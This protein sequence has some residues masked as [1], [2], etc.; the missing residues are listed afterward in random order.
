VYLNDGFRDFLLP[1]ISLPDNS[2]NEGIA[3]ADFDN[4]GTLD[5]VIA[6]GGGQPD[7]VFGNDGAGNFTLLAELGSEPTPIDADVNFASKV[8]PAPTFSHDVAVADFNGDG[9]TDIVIAAIGGNP[10]YAGDGFGGFSPYGTLLGT[11]DSHAVAVA[12]FN[13]TTGPDIVFANV[14]G[15]SQVWLNNGINGFVAG[16]SLPIGDAVAVTVGQFGGDASPDLAFGRVPTINGDVPANPVLINDGSGNF[17]VPVALLGTS[18]TSDVLAG[19]V[20]GDGLTDLVFVNASGVHQ[21]WTATGT[22]FELY[23]EQIVDDGATAGVLT[24]LGFTDVDDPGGL[25]LALGGG[26]QVGVGVYLNDGFGN[27]GRGDAVPP[28]LTLSGA[29]VVDVPAGSSYVDAGATAVDNIDGDISAAIVVTAAVNTSVVGSYTVTYNVSDFAGNPATAIT[30]TVNVNPAAG[31]GGGGGGG[32]AITY[33]MLML[34]ASIV[35][36]GHLYHARPIGAR[37][38]REDQDYRG[39]RK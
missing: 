34:L 2:A 35:A 19:D 9:N 23:S 12:N 21:I 28:V 31:T 7:R 20:N 4:N 37:V 14:G 26:I 24:E 16:E 27:L 5:I 13:G 17:G 18:P 11:A 22:G 39:C 10:V 38:R 33:W 1:P 29:E 25:D 8:V 36:M 30:R 6:N 32:G 3:L 15:D